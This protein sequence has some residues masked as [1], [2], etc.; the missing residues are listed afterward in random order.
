MIKR[1]RFLVALGAT[2]LAGAGA[3]GL[4]YVGS[5]AQIASYVRRRLS[6][7][8]LDAAGLNAYARDQVGVLLAKRPTWSRMKYHFLMAFSKSYSRY[9][10][11]NDTRSRSQR[12]EDTFVSTYLL[13]SDFFLNGADESRTVQYLGFYDPMH[14]CG[15]PFAR[16]PPGGAA[17]AG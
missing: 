12:I 4:G 7:L 3:L 2:A 14:P 8:H 10:R 11:S 15:N 17:D 5:E 16:P 9:D 1:R 13:S 6:F